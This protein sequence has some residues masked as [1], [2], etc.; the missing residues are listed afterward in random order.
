MTSRARIHDLPAWLVGMTLCIGLAACGNRET[1]AV[2]SPAAPAQAEIAWFAGS[3]QEAFVEAKATNRPV[4][5]FWGA[6]W[7]PYCQQLKSSVFTRRDFIEK[8]RLFV[9]VYL[10]GDDAGAQKWGETLKVSGYPTVLI[11]SPDGTELMRVAGGMDVAR[12]TELLDLALADTRPVAEI[13]M[14]LA[15][16]ESALSADDCRRRASSGARRM[17]RA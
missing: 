10:D 17:S 7:C 11:L 8:S 15:A 6:A 9:P 3:A 4:F 5:L 14:G 16:N 12:Y 1:A 2:Q 13:L